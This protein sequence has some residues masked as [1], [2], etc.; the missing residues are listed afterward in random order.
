MSY[1]LNANAPNRYYINGDTVYCTQG[2]AEPT[3]KIEFCTTTST[4]ADPVTVGSGTAATPIIADPA[5]P[6][7]GPNYTGGPV[8]QTNGLIAPDGII[9]PLPASANSA[10]GQPSTG[11]V[12]LY[13]EKKVN[14]FI[15]GATN[16]TI[17]TAGAGTYTNDKSIS[18]K[19]SA[20]VAPV[21]ISGPQNGT[22][23]TLAT[24]FVDTPGS[25]PTNYNISPF[26]SQAEKL[27][28]SGSFNVYVGAETVGGTA[29]MVT[30]TC[31]GWDVNSA[32][33]DL[34]NPSLNTIDL[35]GCTSPNATDIL[36]A[37]HQGNWIAGPGAAIEAN[38]A[39]G[40]TVLTQIGEGKAV[41]PSNSQKLFS[42]NEDYEVVRAAY[43][44]DGINF[45]DLGAISGSTSGAPTL[46][47]TTAAGGDTGAY[48]DISNPFQQAS[49][50]GTNTTGVAAGSLD[51]A[52]PQGDS[53][54]NLPIG[55]ADTV[56]MRWPGARGT[57]I[58]NPDGSIGM[59]LSGAWASDGDSDA[60]NQ[61]FYTQSS[62]GGQELVDADGGAV[63]RLHL[64]GLG[65]PRRQPDVRAWHLGLLLGP[66]L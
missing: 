42:N 9:G 21:S 36:N 40:S 50:A 6:S 32:I 14:Y 8:S 58:T 13:T 46:G 22:S 31:T 5:I 1:L 54:A 34:Y 29:E 39:S 19:Q 25:T 62:N 53:P 20:P 18:S 37:G 11:K 59:F 47:S 52:N 63:H 66:C 30:M 15:E 4:T 16:G 55:S 60:F 17:A 28:S 3:T 56:E 38:N 61:I 49:P 41:T 24:G 10:W 51:T 57:I 64:R 2:N 44:T 12:V 45:T 43:T 26:P 27:P 35:I 7:A 65:R 33:A 48:D 23:T